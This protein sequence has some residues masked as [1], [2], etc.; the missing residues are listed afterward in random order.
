MI[1]KIFFILVLLYGIFHAGRYYEHRQIAPVVADLGLPCEWK[2]AT[3]ETWYNIPDTLILDSVVI[4][5]TP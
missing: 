2:S 3:F 4:V 5:P 1:Y